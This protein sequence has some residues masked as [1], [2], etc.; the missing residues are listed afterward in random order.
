MVWTFD[1]AGAGDIKKPARLVGERVGGSLVCVVNDQ[2]LPP[3]MRVVI[4]VSIVM[5][6][7]PATVP[8]P[9]RTGAEVDIATANI[10]CILRP[11]GPEMGEAGTTT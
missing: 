1:L 9:A 4:M 8:L 3:R 2:P 11:A 5:E 10:S 7:A 6:R